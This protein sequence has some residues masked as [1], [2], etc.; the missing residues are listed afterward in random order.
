[1]LS[2]FLS[3]IEAHIN[4]CTRFVCYSTPAHKL[5]FS[6]DIANITSHFFHSRLAIFI[7]LSPSLWEEVHSI[8]LSDET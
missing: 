3:G 4:I 2:L 7:D 5:V 1:M 6:F 8:I